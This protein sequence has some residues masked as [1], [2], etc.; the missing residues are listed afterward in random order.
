[1]GTEISELPR[2]LPHSLYLPIWSAN[3][4]GKIRTSRTRRGKLE[5]IPADFTES[6]AMHISLF[7]MSYKL[8]HASRT[9]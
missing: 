8:A 6:L 1:M 3:N 9:A 7:E 2:L 4:F 5:S